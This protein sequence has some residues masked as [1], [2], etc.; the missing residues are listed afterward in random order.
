MT[1]MAVLILFDF[2]FLVIGDGEETGPAR[3]C[4]ERCCPDAS[5]SYPF[6]RR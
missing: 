5:D 2:S 6:G 3:T 1:Y 4:D